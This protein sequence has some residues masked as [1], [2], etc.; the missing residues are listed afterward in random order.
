M[1]VCVCVCVERVL[2]LCIALC[3]VA[4][5]LSRT[6]THTHTHTQLSGFL[7]LWEAMKER[8]L[9]HSNYEYTLFMISIIHQ[10]KECVYTHTHTHTHT[11][12]HITSHHTHTHTHTH[13]CLR[14]THSL[15]QLILV[16]HHA[17]RTHTTRAS[18][19]CHPH[20]HTHTHNTHTHTHT[21]TH[22]TGLLSGCVVQPMS[23]A[24]SFANAS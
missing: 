17:A 1:C 23:C 24:L 21:H 8:G 7:K 11:S 19:L 20:L 14:G 16:Y 3:C 5:A 22:F 18:A 15:A 10:L 12:H 6:H 2:A 9:K 4:C 13:T